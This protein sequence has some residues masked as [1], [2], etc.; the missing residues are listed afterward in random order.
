[1]A[2]TTIE[3]KRHKKIR[4]LFDECIELYAARDER[5]FSFFS[6]NFSGYTFGGI[7]LITDREAWLKIVRQDFAEVPGRIRFEMHDIAI[8]VQNEQVVMVNAFCNI[9]LPITDH[10]LS[11]EISRLS[12]TFRF[13]G[14]AW[15]I[16]HVGF[17]IP[18]HLI[19]DGE[20]YPVGNL[21][22]NNRVLE[23]LVAERTRE[24]K[25]REEFYHLFAEDTHDV[26]WRANSD[27]FITYISPSDE[28]FRGYKPEEVI[29]QHV[30]ELFTQEGVTI[31]HDAWQKSMQAERAGSPLN[32]V[33]F[34]APHR[35]KDGSEIWG[36]IYSSPIR[37]ERGNITGFHGITRRSPLRKR[38]DEYIL[39][40]A[41]YDTLTELPNRRLFVDRLNQALVASK[42]SGRCS[43]VLFVDLD[44]FKPLN[45]THGHAV[46]DLLLIEVAARL[47]QCMREIDSVARF[48]GD[49]FV[50]LLR[51]F[52]TDF[53]KSSVAAAA[54]AEKV[55]ARLAEPYYMA[56]VGEN[57][58]KNIIEHRCS[59]SIGVFV[60]KGE[61]ITAENILQCADKA[62]YAAK[63]AGRNRVCFYKA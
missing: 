33:H 24:F 41:F 32:F 40:L 25:E 8:Q 63:K 1:M 34:E 6:N 38:T 51:E 28:Y 37:D 53:E 16:V 39:Q 58:S 29:G 12:L 9:H 26:I 27:L 20:V 47:K 60:F 11:R 10:I 7:A 4:A 36:E 23:A 21:K 62:M 22:E 55:R 13:E 46:G 18:Y 3:P 59:A 19:Q 31:V 42:R 17:S 61:E 44:N 48:G 54:V 35:C 49:E 30:F 15:K 2:S 50:I 43:A 57:A 52:G 56:A 14:N 45:D 5:L